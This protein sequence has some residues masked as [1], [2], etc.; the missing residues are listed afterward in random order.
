MEWEFAPTNGLPDQG[1]NNPLIQPYVGDHYSYLAREIIQN[2]IDARDDES[3]P[4]KVEFNLSHLDGE[5][6]PGRDDLIKVLKL[7][8]KYDGNINDKTAQKFLEKALEVISGD[9]LPILRCSD[10]NTIGL[11]GGENEK[12]KSWHKLIKSRGAS[13]KMGGEGG[14]FG[15]GKGAPYATSDL[16]V[17]FY[18]NVTKNGDH[19]FQGL[20]ELVSFELDDEVRAGSGS[21]G[22]EKYTAIRH[23]EA[24]P[25]EFLRNQT[26]LDVYVAG[27]KN[28]SGWE[29]EL[30]KS[31]LRN[32][33]YAIYVGDLDVDVNGVVINREN[34][35][36]NLSKYYQTE[37]LKGEKEPKGN[38]FHF[39]RSLI[40]GEKF[41]KKLD[42][43]GQ[44][45]FY[46]IEMEKHLN[47][48]A[49]LRKPHMTV[50]SRGYRFPAPYAGVFICEGEQGNKVLR[51]MEPP[52]H[53]KWDPE[54]VEDSSD[55]K[56]LKEIHEWVRECLK[57][58]QKVS[59]QGLIAIPELYKYLPFDDGEG[60]GFGEKEY[61]GEEAEIESSR[62]LQKE[63]NLSQSSV[64]K[65]QSVSVVNEPVKGFG[66]GGS[67]I[68][69]G[70]R[71]K[72][73]GKPALGGGEGKADSLTVSDLKTRTFI[74]GEKNSEITYKILI[75]TDDEITCDLLLQAVGD[76]GAER[77]NI[78]NAQDQNN[79]SI[80]FNRNK[81]KKITLMKGKNNLNVSI[82][83]TIKFALRIKAYEV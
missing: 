53:D 32:F 81:L 49:M 51:D 52:A 29:D 70:K 13:S 43:A 21:F 67:I 58:M 42:T 20:A 16:R 57:S 69:K 31:V 77:I 41:K 22:R 8:K 73:S 37:D 27:F 72:K 24:I 4:V 55:K 38:P 47:R 28:T 56:V 68:R 1:I 80:M 18:S 23:K 64:I 61:T 3:I 6:F 40:H 82:K 59:P 46:F 19:I 11:E 44:V 62:E 17:I 79:N 33:W 63:E 66:G 50:Y 78:V 35:E 75:N 71:K 65:P 74:I 10:Y 36:F 30:I 60:S 14:S 12:D 9:Q 25:D 83:S 48:I 7:C 34:L 76:E 54:R 15:I 5:K 45:Y 2:S 39:Y 26:G